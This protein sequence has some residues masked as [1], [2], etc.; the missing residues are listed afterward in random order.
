M[1]NATNYEIKDTQGR[2]LR[3]TMLTASNRDEAIETI[4]KAAAYVGDPS[5]GEVE[6]FED[7]IELDGSSVYARAVA[8]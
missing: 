6:V 3:A 2:H 4:R 5:G 1:K 7:R 8:S